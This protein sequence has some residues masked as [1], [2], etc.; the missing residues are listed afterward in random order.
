MTINPSKHTAVKVNLL[1][2]LAILALSTIRTREKQKILTAMTRPV[3]VRTWLL[4][5]WNRRRQMSLNVMSQ[6]TST[7]H[8][9]PVLQTSKI[10]VKY[11]EIGTI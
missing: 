3:V 2:M 11:M 6:I 5:S 4:S 1:M 8:L 9:H 7:K 10:K